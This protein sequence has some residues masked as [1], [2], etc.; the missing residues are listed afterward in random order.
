MLLNPAMDGREGIFV[1]VNNSH[2][3]AMLVGTQR[4]SSFD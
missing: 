4:P 2:W 1:D 3:A